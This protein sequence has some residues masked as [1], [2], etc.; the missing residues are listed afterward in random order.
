MSVNMVTLSGNITRDAELHN[1]AATGT[2]VL[3]FSIAVND[4]RRNNATGEWEDHANFFDITVFGKRAE[5]IHTW[6]LKGVKVVVSGKLR[7]NVW[8]DKNTGQNRSRV[9]IIADEIDFM[10]RGGNGNGGAQN[11]PAQQPTPQPAPQV[12]QQQTPQAQPQASAPANS[13]VAS[14]AYDDEDVP[15]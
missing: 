7:Q 3:D 8:Q 5:A 1:T 4:R 6:C 15:F 2:A 10:S 12:T 9:T 14:N 11:A 13:Y